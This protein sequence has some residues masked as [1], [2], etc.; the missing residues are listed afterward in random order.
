MSIVR[1]DPP[2]V[3]VAP[4]LPDVDMGASEDS[5]SVTK[6]GRCLVNF[7]RHPPNGAGDPPT[8]WVCPQCRTLLR[9]Q[10]QIELTVGA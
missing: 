3:A 8:W 2:L 1:I 7:V 4:Q 9:R 10:V 5:D 6:C